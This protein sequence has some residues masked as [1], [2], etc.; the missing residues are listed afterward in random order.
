MAGAGPPP[1]NLIGAGLGLLAFGC[2]AVYDISVK[3]LGG[4]YHPF[5]IMAA[6]G[7][8]SLPLLALY[9]RL[10]PEPGNLRPRRPGW[11]ALR[12]AAVT[13][14]GVLATY[15]FANLPL[16]QC[17]A[18]FFTMPLF[19]AALSVPLLGERI[20]LVRGLAILLGLAGVLIALDPESAALQWGH[21][22]ALGGAAVGALNY[23][24]IRKMGG[25]ERTATLL[26]WPLVVQFL[27]VAATMPF[28]FRPMPV[29]DLAVA[30][31]MAVA[32][33]VGMLLVIA[34]YHRAPAI[35][36]APMQYSQIAW[37]AV[38]GALLFDEAMGPRTLLGT[39]LIAVAGILVVARQDRPA[40]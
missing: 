28:V 37:A 22:A 17:Y 34:A 13:V 8:M 16:A 24:I 27:V 35:V 40:A 29:A 20:D 11:M 10:S 14:N 36:V 18:I 25:V 26:I 32:V 31:V 33:V 5:Q 9:A 1:S 23:V 2:F 21:A 3:F 30:A 19:I 4:G 39:G 15:A 12:A 38:F 6:A 7:L